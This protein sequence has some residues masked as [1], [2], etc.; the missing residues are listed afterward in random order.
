MIL[1]EKDVKN[2]EINAEPHREKEMRQTKPKGA[3]AVIAVIISTV[4]GAVLCGAAGGGAGLPVCAALAAVL[5]PVYGVCVFVGS[6]AAYLAF[7]VTD[8]FA[9]DIIA[10]PLL[11]CV[12]FF[13]EMIL[14]GRPSSRASAAMAGIVYFLGGT[15]AAFASKLTFT[16][17]LA[18]FFRGIIC[19]AVAYFAA[20]CAED[21]ISCG[22]IGVTGE[23]GIGTAVLYV[24]AIAALSC[25]RA[26]NF[27]VGRAA[28]IFVILAAGC[29]FG[30]GGSAAAGALTAL[31]IILG[32]AE[33]TDLSDMVRSSALMTCSGL[34]SG[35]FSRWGRTA[36]AVSYAASILVLMLFMGRLQWAAALMTDTGIAALLYCFIPDR[37]YLKAVNGVSRPCSAAVR[38]CGDGAAFAAYA[39]G[40]IRGNVSKAADILGNNVKERSANDITD[41]VCRKVCC[42]VC[43]ECRSCDFCCKGSGSRRKYVFPTVIRLLSAKGFITEKELPKAVE[44]CTKKTELVDCFNDEYRRIGMEQRLSETV[45]GMWDNLCEQLSA[46]E[47]MLREMGGRCGGGRTYDD[48]LSERVVCLIEKYG[49]KDPSAAVYFDA[50]A[51]IYVS[52][53][54]HRQLDI[55]VGRFTEKLSAVTDR[56]LEAPETVC[57]NGT[58][59]LRWHEIPVFAIEEGKAVLCGREDISGDSS[60]RFYDGF[61]NVYYII[62]D[63]MGSGKRAALESSMTVSMLIR[64]IKAGVGLESAVKKV[65]LMLLAKSGDEV[66]ATADILCINL[67]SGR[68]D[69]LKLGAAQTLFKTG[70]VV[71]AVESRSL[72]LGIIVPAQF[73]HRTL[74]LSDGDCAV[75]FSDGIREESFPKVRE[76]MLSDGYSPQRCAD[77]VAE[78]GKDIDPSHADDKT[79]YV[80]KLHK[81]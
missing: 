11:V 19:G 64:L 35:C 34:V 62:S 24:L 41:E 45:E 31:G 18:V 16:L 21:V 29:R 81:I 43:T 60:C 36:A 30:S 80:V 2:A 39:L 53:F 77:A 54:F 40:G 13:A 33:G 52:C 7:G 74:H 78:Y 25:A 50:C 42:K 14:K 68:A 28:G 23:K 15:A 72:P 46:E 48:S 22:R 4:S 38:Y 49:G 1:K 26:G 6:A 10:M 76:L 12:R 8:K 67:F 63:G 75:M 71:K 73:E 55:S 56:D 61:G 70:G 79:V 9:A 51:H 58:I 20:E 69:T 66:F 5:S 57:E 59:C 32:E 65:N 27:C 47:D 44:G 37:L 3:A 17:M